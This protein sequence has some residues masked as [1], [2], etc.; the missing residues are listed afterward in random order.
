MNNEMMQYFNE[1]YEILYHHNYH[2][3]VAAFQS[4]PKATKAFDLI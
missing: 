1:K 3:K 2:L 4:R